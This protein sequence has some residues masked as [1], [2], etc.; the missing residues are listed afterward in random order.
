[1]L[2]AISIFLMVKIVKS[3]LLLYSLMLCILFSVNCGALQNFVK[4]SFILSSS[5]D[6][7]SKV[8]KT[9]DG[10]VDGSQHA[11]S[12]A[13]TGAETYDASYSSAAAYSAAASAYNY[14]T[15]L[16]SQWAAYSAAQPVGC[17]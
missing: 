14:S 9:E 2:S 15:P 17:Q 5:S 4:R 6:I 12:T 8:S 13:L 10:I 7:K 1:M 16:Q 11:T 3:E